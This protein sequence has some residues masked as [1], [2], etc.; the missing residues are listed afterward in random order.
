MFIHVLFVF[1]VTTLLLAYCRVRYVNLA[2]WSLYINKLTYLTYLHWAHIV[3]SD[4][5]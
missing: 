5:E 4:V 3:C 1:C 2:I